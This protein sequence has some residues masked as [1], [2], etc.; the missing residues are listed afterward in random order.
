MS[1]QSFEV[2][3]L[4]ARMGRPPKQ[5]DWDVFEKLCGLQCTQQEIADFFNIHVQTLVIKIEIEYN[6]SF[7]TVY[8][9]YSNC[10]KVSLRRTQFAL[11]RRSSQMA[12]RLGELWLDQKA[13]TDVISPKEGDVILKDKYYAAEY[14]VQKLQ[15]EIDDLKSK[16]SQELQRSDTPIQPVDR[17]S[18]LG[19]DIQ[20]S[21]Q[22]D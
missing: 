8:R 10:G 22:T 5:L 18:E 14:R 20:L 1:T 11:A 9:I 7:P 19:E 4:P 17:S 2:E 16:A 13:S 15:R 12:I 21:R 3:V 6:E